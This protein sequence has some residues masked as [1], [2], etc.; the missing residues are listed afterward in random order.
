VALEER[1]NFRRITENQ[2]VVAA[3]ASDAPEEALVQQSRI[4]Q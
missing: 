2:Q 3:A 1:N 4:T